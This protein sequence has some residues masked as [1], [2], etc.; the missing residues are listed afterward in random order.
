MEKAEFISIEDDE[1]DLILS[2]AL[3]DEDSGVK[4]LILMRTPLYESILPPEERGVKVSMEGG[5]EDDRNM[6]EKITIDNNRVRIFT[7]EEK[8]EV[9]ISAIEKFEYDEMTKFVKQ[10]NF[11]SCFK[12]VFA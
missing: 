7:S 4:S 6:L 1:P 12:I 8:Y 2:F 10:L 9:D 5:S 11:D 3:E